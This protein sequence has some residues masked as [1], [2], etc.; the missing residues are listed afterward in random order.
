MLETLRESGQSE[1]LCERCGEPA[2]PVFGDLCEECAAEN[3][4]YL[5]TACGEAEAVC[6]YDEF[7][8]LCES[9]YAEGRFRCT[10]CGAEDADYVM[11]DYERLCYFCLKEF[12]VPRLEEELGFQLDSD[13]EYTCLN[14]RYSRYG[15][16]TIR[17]YVLH[18]DVSDETV[19]KIEDFVE[20][21]S[22]PLSEKLP[23]ILDG[24]RP[25]FEGT[26]YITK[27]T[28]DWLVRYWYL[29]YWDENSLLRMEFRGILPK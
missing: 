25:Y 20:E 13:T 11:D 7:N 18:R 4:R 16:E 10:K 2:H 12:V 14:Y 17:L 5:C 29:H 9:C 6:D 1:L 19:A 15:K 26:F 3:R 27:E 21:E 28:L 22:K 8:R 23:E 24:T